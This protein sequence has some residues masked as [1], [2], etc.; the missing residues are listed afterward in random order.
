M[1]E[2]EEAVAVT[3][4]KDR[5]VTQSPPAHLPVDGA[6]IAW[7]H[8]FTGIT[9]D[10]ALGALID[11][12]ADLDE[13]RAMC[14]RLPVGGWELEAEPV[15]RGGIGAT[16]VRVREY[17]SSVIRTGAHIEA[18][19]TEARLP[20][21]VRR[22]ASQAMGALF[23]AQRRVH[24]R[25]LE[26]QQLHDV[27]SLRAL[28]RIVGACAAL[29]VLGVDEVHGS[30]VAHGQG[31]VRSANG[32][33]VPLPAP[34]TVELL[35]DAPSYGLEVQT[36]L[37]SPTGAALLSQLSTGW[38]PMPPMIVGA[39]GFGAGPQEITDRPFVTQVVIGA[40]SA[41]LPLGQ[42]VTLLEA[43][44]DDVTGE[45]MSHALTAVLD[46][47]AADAWLTPI[48]AAGGRPGH[49]FSALVDTALADQVA[50]VLVAETGAQALRGQ[51]ME[52]WPAARHHDDVEVTGRRVRVEVSAGRVKVSRDDAARVARRSGLPVR[53][54]VSLAEEAWRRGQR[55]GLIEVRTLDAPEAE[56]TP[57]E[58]PPDDGGPHIA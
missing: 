47:G 56:P 28:L 15:L 24:R 34:T 13:V 38:G 57:T 53:E 37:T 45:T 33:M 54:V 46:A 23:E 20:D 42:P 11:A 51:R 50:A 48:V 2:A 36:E 5:G 58:G 27:G 44:L 9:G 35:R 43:N 17:D 32:G 18:L 49:T 21:R 4:G 12:G 30:H 29:E 19:V 3:N 41:E 1:V 16:L 26:Q 39:S 40:R 10:T 14:D 25:G 6:T 52:R 55:P 22:R 31:M 7:F 8:C